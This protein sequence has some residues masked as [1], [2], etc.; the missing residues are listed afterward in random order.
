MTEI[1]PLYLLPGLICDEVIWAAQVRALSD[2]T[3]VVVPDYGDARSLE[4][5]A[6]RVLRSAPVKIS[7]A[8]HS[9]GGRVALEIL[10]IA[11][12]RVERLALLD[13]GVHAVEPG[14]RE[15][16]LALLEIGRRMGMA[17]LVDAWLP[18][19]VHPDRRRDSSFMTPLRNMCVNV[20][21]RKFENHITALLGRTDQQP[22]LSKIDCATLVAVGSADLWS[23]VSQHRRIAAGIRDAELVIFEGAGHMAPVEEPDQVNAALRRWLE[24][25]AR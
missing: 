5:M 11:A 16:R 9:M 20:G 6:G 14:E 4:A 3:D 10:R 23:P 25:E 8:G 21:L 13:T 7:L 19:M 22:I 17:A 1:A 24:R 15:K 2:L 18:P 12:D